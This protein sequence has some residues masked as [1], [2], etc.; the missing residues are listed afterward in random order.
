M[1]ICKDIK[2][3]SYMQYGYINVI[4]INLRVHLITFT[5]SIQAT[6]LVFLIHTK[7]PVHVIKVQDNDMMSRMLRRAS[8]WNRLQTA[9]VQTWMIRCITTVRKRVRNQNTT[10]SS[11]VLAVSELET[12]ETIMKSYQHQKIKLESVILV[13]HEK[14]TL[15][16]VIG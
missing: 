11:K 6:T 13:V 5:N 8:S 1:L 10:T 3:Y 4:L 16:E 12:A 14:H 15:K 9:K 7:D 2:M